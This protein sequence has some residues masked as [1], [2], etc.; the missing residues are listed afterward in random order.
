MLQETKVVTELAGVA[1]LHRLKVYEAHGG[2]AALRKALTEMKP[3][4]VIEVVKRSG[5]RGKGGAGFPAGLKWGFVP[6]DHP[7]PKYLAANADEGEPGTFKDRW[8]IEHNPHLLIEGSIIASYAAGISQ[9]YVYTRGEFFTGR[10]V[11]EKAIKEAYAKGYL[12]E[13]VIGSGYA[14]EM[15]VHSGAGSYECGE[16]TALLTSLEGGRGHPKMKPPFPATHGGWGKPT[17][18]NNV[19]TLATVPAII[20]RGADWHRSLGTDKSPGVKMV[21]ISGQV[22]KPGNYEIALGTPVRSIID[23]LGGGVWKGRALK[24][25]MP[26]GSST[27][28]LTPDKLDTPYDYESIGEV[29]SMLG[30]GA[31]IVFDET[32]DM[33]RVAEILTR[34]YAWESCGKCTPCREGTRW[35][36]QIYERILNGGGRMEDLPLLLDICQGIEFKSFCPFG[37]AAVGA[38]R[39]TIQHFRDEYE[40]YIRKH[41]VYERKFTPVRHR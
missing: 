40:E 8:I 20:N 1:D 9:A 28:V 26:G 32:A 3:E 14:L 24:G 27:P 10:E 5:L 33:V 12:G 31:I 38:V 16:E 37:D 7:G 4:E 19:E 34:F 17:V 30:S 23:D 6:R 35:M 39:S 15:T 21:S 29:G 2:Y 25:F 22:G 13:D 11:L 41:K 18:I 36:L